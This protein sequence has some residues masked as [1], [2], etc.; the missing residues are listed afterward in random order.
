MF[1][2]VSRLVLAHADDD[3]VVRAIGMISAEGEEVA[4]LGSHSPG[5]AD[6]E[7]VRIACVGGAEEWLAQVE[8]A[9]RDTVR[10]GA[11]TDECVSAFRSPHR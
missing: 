10:E 2:N 8:V 4:F 6:H 9:M 7:D 1:D 5:S 3:D 11:T